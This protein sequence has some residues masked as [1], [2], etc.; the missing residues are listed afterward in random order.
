MTLHIM[1]HMPA[2]ANP[3]SGVQRARHSLGGL[4]FRPK[5]SSA[6]AQVLLRSVRVPYPFDIMMLVR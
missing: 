1:I 2:L 3:K 4:I 6:K 5:H